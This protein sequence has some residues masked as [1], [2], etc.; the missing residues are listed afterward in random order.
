MPV[1]CLRLER[2][3]VALDFRGYG[4]GYLWNV[5]HWFKLFKVKDRDCLKLLMGNF[6]EKS[7]KRRYERGTVIL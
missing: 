4:Y 1:Y 3:R 5:K 2:E 7:K 6:L